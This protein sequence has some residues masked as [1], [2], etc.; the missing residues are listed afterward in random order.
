LEDL[1]ISMNSP[2]ILVVISHWPSKAHPYLTWLYYRLKEV[3]PRLQFFIFSSSDKEFGEQLIG[4]EAVKSCLKNALY[5]R[6]FT[7]NPFPHLISC[8]K[9]L[10]NIKQSYKIFLYCRA[11]G[12]S[13][14]QCYG[15][16]YYFSSLL[17]KKFDLIYIN[18]LQTA[19]HFRSRN[20]FGNTPIIASSRGQD[21]DFEPEGFDNVLT[22]IDHLHV[23]GEYLKHKAVSRS[24]PPDQ[25]TII[26]PAALPVTIRAGNL[27]KSDKIITITSA[28]RLAWTKGYIYSL[29]AV[30]MVIHQLPDF[31]INYH[32]IGDGPEKE[33]LQVEAVRLGI[34]SN[35]IFHGWQSQDEVNK[36]V[37]SADIYLL[38]SIEEGFN[39]S[40][41]QA[42]NLGIPCVVSNTGG[43][44]ENVE[45]GVTGL[46]IPRYDA[47]AAAKALQKLIQEPALRKQ[48]GEAASLRVNQHFSLEKQVRQYADMFENVIRNHEDHI[49]LQ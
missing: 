49:R 37:F 19:K 9:I 5:R 30:S 45:D 12:S 29:R 7:L 39:N 34:Q 2:K 48:M 47:D 43:L 40:V 24:F 33:F 3:Y 8:Y 10:T 20:I 11:K 21:F 26:P 6:H 1:T 42:Q 18:A 17:G 27:V 31:H 32:I 38:L 4:K 15:Q 22:Q 35:V 36:L 28:S 23:L 16:L 25:I 14:L 44:P 46:V 41:L 13:I